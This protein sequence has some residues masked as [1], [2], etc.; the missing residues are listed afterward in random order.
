L[1]EVFAFNCLLAAAP[2]L[3]AKDLPGGHFASKFI[4]HKSSK[5]SWPGAWAA[6]SQLDVFLFA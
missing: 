4:V 2:K 3:F 6:P 1:V 5:I